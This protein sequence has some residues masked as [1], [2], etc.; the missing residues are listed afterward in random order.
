MS[1]QFSQTFLRDAD[2]LLQILRRSSD[3]AETAR[4]LHSIK[5]GAAF[6]G[7]DNLENTAHA[8]EDRM[9]A[10]AVDWNEAVERLSALLEQHRRDVLNAG[11]GPAP[12][13]P[14]RA[15]RFSALER[16]VL[17]ESRQRGERFYRLVC[18]VDQAAV[19]PYPRAYLVS[20][21]LET[22]TT[23][24]KT[25]PPM[26]KPEFNFSQPVFWLTTDR[27]EDE[28][29]RAA[30]VDLV[31]VVELRGLDYTDALSREELPAGTA[32]SPGAADNEGSLLVERSRYTELWEV[33]EELA[34]TMD[35]QGEHS[36]RSSGE[37]IKDLQSSLE[38]LA[39]SPLE[40][41]LSDI[42]DGVARIAGRRG[43]EAVFQWETASG[44]LDSASLDV[45]S[46]ILQQLIRNS[47]RHGIESPDE[48][49]KSGKNPQARLLL[50]ME[51]S[52]KYYRFRFEDD[53]RGIDEKAVLE[54]AERDGL[55]APQNAAPDSLLD[56]LC[57]PGFSSA[58]TADTD[59]GRGFG[60]EMVRHLLTREFESELELENRPGEGTVF[61]W[62]FP[63][64]HLR[65]PY[66]VFVAEGR[67]WA[68]P[69]DAVYRR[70][71]MDP[72][73]I[74]ASGQAY[75]MADGLV[76]MVSP[77]GLLAPGTI[78][79]Y[80]VEIRHRG[81]RA[82]LPVDELLS[83]EPWSMQDLTASDPASP[84]CRA[85]KDRRGNIPILSPAVVYAAGSVRT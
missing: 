57:H 43:L 22:A 24:V 82:V 70:G 34:W 5:S 21:R 6:L 50:R 48:R 62:S 37:L 33:A 9:A 60:L 68:L 61:S 41:M 65:R 1:G 49:V 20:S 38:N 16:R 31:S 66:L 51:R 85:L 13:P 45:L 25:E 75:A 79:E 72:G 77:L 55:T 32:V 40:P 42:A 63:E 14:A 44:G 78:K 69:M 23:L 46:E 18:K 4:A 71:L 11:E 39:Y 47:L 80:M 26:D 35:H 36:E 81:R 19:L 64:K 58:D 29:Y 8:L 73:K 54:Q 15:I 83:E 59:G 76:P 53:G 30:N 84:W 52:G 56:I 10:G 7:W 27:S 12:R 67:S 17:E 2:E 74:N 3:K 28:I